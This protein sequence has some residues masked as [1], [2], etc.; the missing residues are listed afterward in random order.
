MFKDLESE[1]TITKSTKKR[2]EGQS[3]LFFGSKKALIGGIIAGSIALGGQWLVGQIYSGWE[4][5][6]LL[7]SVISSALFFGSSIVTAAATILALMLTMLG[8]TH[9]SESEFD[10]VFYKRIERISLLSTISL[11]GGVLLLQ[12]LS[13]PLQE[14]DEVPAYWY[15]IIY[16]ILIVSIAG[17]AG[18]VVGIVL[19]LF[20]SIRSLIKVISPNIEEEVDDARDEQEEE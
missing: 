7:E 2:E 20:N 11:V 16:Y 13:I 14:S 5:R 1:N 19:M 17:L 9:Q 6:R 8:L 12:F 18:L 15:K 4:A 10:P 3:S